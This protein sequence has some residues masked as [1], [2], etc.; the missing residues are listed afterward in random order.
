V[1]NVPVPFYLVGTVH[2]LSGKDYPLPKA[3]DQVL[4]DSKR[5]LFELDPNPKSDFGK[6]FARAAIY[7]KGDNIRR[8]I[9]AETWKFLE[10]NFSIS[11]YVGKKQWQWG[12]SHFE[13][14]D[15][16]RPWAIAYFIW[17]IRGY[18]DVFSQHGVDNHLAYQA[19][20]MGKEVAGLETDQEHVD[21]LRGMTDTESEIIL[22][23]VLIRGDKRRDDYNK[24]RDAWK[25]G[26]IATIWAENQRFRNENPGGDLRLLDERNVKWIPKI[27]AEMQTGKPTSIV[28]GCLH[29]GGPNGVVAL[30]Q[31]GGYQV[32]QL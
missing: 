23:D 30:L 6:I 13:T 21:V 18:N 7:P 9:H 5:L 28:A 27:K 2:A 12:D 8:H 15:E 1:T 19:R 20:R 11:N 10:K 17:G 25:R 26:D 31:R 22:L 4:R 14:I 3:Y 29:F 24:V 16:M 32:E